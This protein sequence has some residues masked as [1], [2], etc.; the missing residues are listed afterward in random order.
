MHPCRMQAHQWF[1][2]LATL[3]DWTELWM[4]EGLATYLETVVADAFQPDMGYL[5]DF[6]TSTTSVGEPPNAQ[7]DVS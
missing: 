6:F 7:P 1:G 4:N 3:S 5:A 2:N